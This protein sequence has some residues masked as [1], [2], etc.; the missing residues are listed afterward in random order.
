MPSTYSA[1]TYHIVFSTKDRVP[2]IESEW[3]ERFHSY[4]GGTARGLNGTPLA[5]GGVADHI[6]LLVILKP[7]HS[8][9]D[10]V[11]DLKKSSS[12]WV[13]DELGTK[14]FAWQEG[15]AVFTVGPQGIGPCK[16]Y[17][18]GQPEHHRKLSS[19]DELLALCEE[20]GIEV[21]LRYFD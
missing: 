14:R 6:H 19:R 8:I 9:A 11:R 3:I 4:I 18:V 20:A 13:R 5:V 10:F 7:T 17:I 16:R 2:F 15:Y 12:G 1:L 21:D